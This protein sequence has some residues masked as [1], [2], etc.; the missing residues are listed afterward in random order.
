MK[1]ITAF[2]DTSVFFSENFIDS[3][4]IKQLLQLAENNEIDLIITDIV[5]NEILSKYGESI[6]I[7]IPIINNTHT[8]RNKSARVLR[9]HD[10][11]LKINLVLKLNHHI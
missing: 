10:D 2:L 5:Y 6:E 1:K 3:R 7:A 11:L 9:N 8:S 4:N